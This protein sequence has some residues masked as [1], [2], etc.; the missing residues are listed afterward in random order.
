MSSDLLHYVRLFS[1]IKYSNMTHYN[2]IDDRL[3]KYAFLKLYEVRKPYS[4]QLFSSNQSMD[5]F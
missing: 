1:Y 3:R 5:F 4:K 2:E